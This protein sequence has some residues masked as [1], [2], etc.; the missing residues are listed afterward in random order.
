MA[1]KSSLNSELRLLSGKSKSG[2]YSVSASCPKAGSDQKIKLLVRN[3]MKITCKSML[4][5]KESLTISNPQLYYI[6]TTNYIIQ[7]A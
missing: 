6:I 4:G 1:G 5:P 2:S 7:P 3:K